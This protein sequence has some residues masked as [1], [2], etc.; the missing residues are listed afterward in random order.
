MFR[1]LVC[2]ALFLVVGSDRVV[3]LLGVLRSCSGPRPSVHCSITARSGNIGVAG[4]A[5]FPWQHFC[6]C[7]MDDEWPFMSNRREVC[8]VE[9]MTLQYA[10]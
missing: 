1:G 8:I 10:L 9:V 3:A 7:Y 6:F 2:V 5:R 4:F